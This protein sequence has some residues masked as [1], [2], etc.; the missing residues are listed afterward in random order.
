MCV[1]QFRAGIRFSFPQEISYPVRGLWNYEA[2]PTKPPRNGFQIGTLNQRVAAQTRECFGGSTFPLPTFCK[3]SAR[4]PQ[5]STTDQWKKEPEI[6]QESLLD[7][8]THPIEE[9]P[10][11]FLF[12]FKE[13]VR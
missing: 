7:S 2:R 8:M 1:G 13:P 9:P 12:L 6:D 3:F 5:H 4:H 10:L 11:F